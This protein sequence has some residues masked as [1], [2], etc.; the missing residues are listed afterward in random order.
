MPFRFSPRPNHASEIRWQPWSEAPFARATA[1]GKLV[2]LSIS[3]VWCHWC[4]VMDEETYSNR[5]VIDLINE[6]FIAVRVDNDERPEINARY[7]MGGWPTTALLTARGEIISGATYV[8]PEAMLL[9]L[10]RVIEFCATQK[11]RIA[12]HLEQARALREERRER[13]RAVVGELDAEMPGEIL[14]DIIER[15]DEEHGGFGGAPKFPHL[16]ALSLL[17]DRWRLARI[18]SP[19]ES[20][21]AT[22]TAAAHRYEVMLRKTL[23][24][25]IH[26]GLYDTEEGGFYRYATEADWSVPHYEKMTEDHAQLLPVIAGVFL[27]T[28]DEDL[29]RVL[30]QT[31][32]WIRG[33]LYD[34]QTGLFGGSQD[35]DEAYA[36]RSAAE[37]R[38][39]PAPFVD[40]AN[41][42]QQTAG[43][44]G[45][46]FSVA[47]ALDDAE[48]ARYAE[49]ALDALH[50]RLRD[51]SGLLYHLLPPDGAPP[52]VERLLTD[53]VAYVNAALDAYGYN[54]AERFLQRAKDLAD[55]LFPI[56][57]H[58]GRLRDHAHGDRTGALGEALYGL[59]ENASAAE[60]LL[61]LSGITE[62]PEYRIRAQSILRH[63]GEQ[64]RGGSLFAAKYAAVL[65][66]AL[67]PCS[68]LHIHADVAHARA[69]LRASKRLPDPYLVACTVLSEAQEHEALF[70]RGTTCAAPVRDADAL[71][72]AWEGL[73]AITKGA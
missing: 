25:M 71:R 70:C 64:A 18:P 4:H 46:L 63:C 12:E 31:W 15:F 45:A 47:D 32:Q 27:M 44:A 41:Y 60:A 9:L 50:D 1:E 72:S 56:F 37:R 69:F 52:S 36:L 11:E 65:S 3:A 35:A 20:D 24:S 23:S 55:R 61:R 54:G 29:R 16:D 26:G 21:R 58:E 13:E 53:Q 6:R 62:E 33:T 73:F 49:A 30:R 17:L 48:I 19:R 51:A 39:Y 14:A 67:G 43:L 59:R 10:E 8:P 2:L 22:L 7:N 68:M 34:E 28:A 38:S 42:T 5:A 66:F 57:G 40:R